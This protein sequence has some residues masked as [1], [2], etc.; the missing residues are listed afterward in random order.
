MKQQCIQEVMRAAGRI[1]ST[2]EIQGIEDRIKSN[3]RQLAIKDRQ[4]FQSMS[5]EARLTEAANMSAKQIVEEAQLKKR[6]LALTIAAH[7]RLES[8]SASNAGGRLDALKRS[9]VFVADGKSSVQS[10]E[11]MHHAIRSNAL[12]QMIDTLEASDPKFFGLFENVDGIKAITR[13]LFGEDSDNQSAKRGAKSWHD[14]T[15]ALKKHFNEVGGK[16]GSLE[17]WALPQ[18]HSQLKVAQAG[19]DQWKA[20]IMAKLDRNRY[21]ND[22]GTLMTDN[23][24]NDFLTHVWETISTGGLNKGVEGNPS[25][26]GM[27]ANADSEH[28]V[29]H[30]KTAEDY[31]NYQMKYGD[32]DMYGI[33]VDH[34][35]ALSR[36]IALVE[37]LGPNPDITFQ[38]F[39]KRG[40]GLEALKDPNKTGKINEQGANLESLYNY[41][42]GKNLPVAN[43][44]LAKGF[45]SLRSWMVASKL[46]S[47][48]ITSL[49]DEATL[50]LTAHVNNLPAIK[51]FRNELSAL[52]PTNQNELRMA[53]RAGLSLETLIGDLNRFGQE[54]LGASFSSKMATV[55]MR[56]SGL[57]ALTAARKRAFG[58]TMMSSIGQLTKDH[59]RL[60]DLD[61]HDNRILLSKGFNEADWNTLKNVVHE[62]W[63]NGNDTMLTPDAIMRIPDSVIPYAQKRET[64]MKYLGA[65]LEETNVAVVEPGAAERA[66]MGSGLQRGTW[67]GELTRSFFLFKSFP[68][69]MIMRH[70]M[71]GMRQETAGGKAVYIASLVAATTVLG[72]V[73][74]EINELLSGRNPKN[75]NPIEGK[76]GVKNWINAMLKGGA[77]G[78]YG[79]FLFSD[80]TQYGRTALS[81]LEGPVFGLAEEAIKITQGNVMSYLKGERTNLGK[82]AS[83]LLKENSFFMNWWYMKAAFDHMIFHQLQEYFSPGY[84]ARMQQRAQTE[85]AQSYWWRPG[86]GVDD[87]QAPE[88]SKIDG[89]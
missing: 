76:A 2:S 63:G 26:R 70:W 53:R 77:L 16:I 3:L 68:L 7:D 44:W 15:D 10:V 13:E 22:D 71:R 19:A 29:I 45:D 69:A 80:T 85:F 79:D 1:L 23:Q 28:R 64:L 57:S 65:I 88:L 4:A 35:G 25:G 39:L 34:I 5:V 49:S 82:D 56:A 30:F 20:D 87:I 8:Y 54:G 37:K 41:I 43:A 52:D 59:A 74:M 47:A 55:T 18:H 73:S 32:K 78:I 67:K 89:D 42:S 50:Y 38:H 75:L 31:L 46:G 83:Q 27:R 17:D 36:N 62:D 9:L 60:A 51:V 86:G 11:S 72:A 14:V 33:M 12:R 58:V 61:L 21:G 6:R 40:K 48:V 84:L 24:L 81:T 66:M